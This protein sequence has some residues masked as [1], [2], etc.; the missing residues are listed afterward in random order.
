MNCEDFLNSFVS[1]YPIFYA[2]F[3]AAR[4]LDHM[5]RLEIKRKCFFPFFFRKKKRKKNLTQFP[6]SNKK[7]KE[8]KGLLS[9]VVYVHGEKSKAKKVDLP[10]KNWW[11]R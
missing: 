4:F 3:A 11:N 10:L 7:K 8:K 5:E 9:F 6:L 2:L 1:Y